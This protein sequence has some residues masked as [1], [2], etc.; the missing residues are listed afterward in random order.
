MKKLIV[1]LIVFTVFIGL[2]DTK[3]C[4][5][6]KYKWGKIIVEDGKTTAKVIIK[7]STTTYSKKKGKYV[8]N[9]KKIIKGNEFG[10]DGLYP[11]IEKGKVKF[12]LAKIGKNLYVK[13]KDKN[14]KLIGLDAEIRYNNIKKKTLSGTVTYQYNQ[15]IGTR[16]DVGALIYAFPTG[17]MSGMVS[18][19]EMFDM[20][21]N[22]NMTLE[23]RIYF[24]KVDGYGHYRLKL[25][26][27]K[28]VIL[29]RSNNAMQILGHKVD[30]ITIDRL[31]DFI[32]DISL[33]NPYALNAVKYKIL[34]IDLNR[35]KS[36]N[37]S[38]DF[39]Y[40]FY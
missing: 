17:F 25:P 27:D 14:V 32:T 24:T 10:I 20:I 31:S 37:Y 13:E 23:R 28:Y 36:E 2:I 12:H 18:Q 16:G 11:F 34:D 19:D 33:S 40:S 35:N 5:A 9:K 26:P 29:I 15:F 3:V 30:K 8:I 39:G 38:V 1:F 7:K 22:P 21:E 4:A 6:E